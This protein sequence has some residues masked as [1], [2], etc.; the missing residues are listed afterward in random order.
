MATW[1]IR[2]GKRPFE[3]SLPASFSLSGGTRLSIQEGNRSRSPEKTQVYGQQLIRKGMQWLFEELAKYLLSH[4]ATNW[5]DLV[6]QLDF[7]RGALALGCPTIVMMESTHLGMSDHLVPRILS[8]WIRAALFRDVLPN[9]LM[10]PCLVEVDHISV[11][12]AMELLLMQNQ[13]VIQAFLPHTTL[14]AVADGVGSWR[15]IGGFEQ[16]DATGRRHMSEAR[17]K[18]GIVIPNQVL[19]RMP[20]RGG[21]SQLLCHPGI[22]WRSCHAHVDHLP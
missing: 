21:F 6:H 17:P 11:E 12:H 20:I 1:D 22:G 3:P 14:E 4:D 19:G 5:M 10:R 16:L 8:G 13:Q 9:P 15:V 18:F 7:R 2:S